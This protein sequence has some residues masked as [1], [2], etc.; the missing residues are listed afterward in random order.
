MLLCII[1]SLFGLSVGVLIAYLTLPTTQTVPAIATCVVL[2]IGV[3]I[4]IWGPESSP[5]YG[6]LIGLSSVIALALAGAQRWKNH[7]LL[8]DAGYWKR[9]GLWV[10]HA[11][12]LRKTNVET[13]E[14][15]ETL[16]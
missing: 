6:I 9:V 13:Q 4:T 8:A 15:A 16:T 11:H 1:A 7:P 14:E 3:S 10:M 5:F 2:V 12:V